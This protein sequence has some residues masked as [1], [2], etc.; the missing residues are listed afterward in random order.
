MPPETP[1]FSDSTDKPAPKPNEGLHHALSEEL[2]QALSRHRVRAADPAPA[3]APAPAETRITPT[4]KLPGRADLS[5]V[6]VSNGV[7]ELEYGSAN[8]DSRLAAASGYST[9]KINDMPQDVRVRQWLNKDGYFFWFQNGQDKREHHHYAAGLKYMNVGSNC[10]LDVQMEQ[11]DASNKFFS[12]DGVHGFQT[13]RND[14]DILGYIKNLSQL[15]GRELGIQ[16]RALAQGAQC[17]DNPYFHLYLSD[18]YMTMAMKP[19]VDQVAHGQT[20]NLDDPMTVRFIDAAISQAKQAERDSRNI[21]AQHRWA[22]PPNVASPLA[23]FAYYTDPYHFWAGGFDQARRREQALITLRNLVATKAIGN[24]VAKS[25]SN[26]V[27]D[28]LPPALPP[29]Q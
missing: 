14:T 4:F 8:F 21:C 3:P 22:P 7:L 5:V 15:T 29:R 2:N 20:P 11:L 17:N 1:T 16:A 28:V 18:T 24:V 19:I 26:G 13:Y 27:D 9:L 10:R 25:M 12:H 6:P 23:P